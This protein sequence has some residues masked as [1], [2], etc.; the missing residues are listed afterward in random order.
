[1]DGQVYIKN[2]L[3]YIC[4]RADENY[5]TNITPI[6]LPMNGRLEIFTCVAFLY[7]TQ[8]LNMKFLL[9]CRHNQND[10][11]QTGPREPSGAHS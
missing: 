8:H 10:G 5:C 4:V 7:I 9:C 11:T 2:V 6:K 3:R 1:M